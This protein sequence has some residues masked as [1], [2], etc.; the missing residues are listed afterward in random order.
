MSYEFINLIIREATYCMIANDFNRTKHS[1][2]YK[3]V[4]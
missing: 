1:G 2:S 4:L 3:L